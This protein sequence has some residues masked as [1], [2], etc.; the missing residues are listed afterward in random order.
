MPCLGRFLVGIA[1]TIATAAPASAQRV[2][3]ELDEF[4]RSIVERAAPLAVSVV[5]VRGD[6]VVHLAGYGL[7]DREQSLPVTPQS[8]FYIASSTK[9]FTAL[10]A[11]LLAARGAVDLDAPVSRYA[12]EF[13]LPP[14]LD[15]SRITLRRLLSHRAGFESG[16]VAFRTAYSGDLVPDSLL[17]VL[18]RSAV[19]V[20]TTFTYTNTAF[21]V[22]ARVLERA[23]DSPWQ[24][25]VAQEILNP[26]GLLRTTAVPSSASDWELVQGYGP[27][28]DGFRVVPPKPDETMH[29]AGGML[30]SG[31]DAGIW[32]RAQL[33]P[34]RVSG[35]QGLPASVIAAT[36]QPHAAHADTTDN[37]HRIGYA[38]GWQIGILDGDTLYYHLGNYPGAFAHVSFIPSRGIGVAV[39]ANS[40]LPAFGPVT[41][42]IATRAY[43]LLLDRRH[44]ER[45]Y[46]AFTDSIGSRRNRMAEIFRVDARR[47]A[48]RPTVPPRGWSVYAGHYYGGDMGSVTIVAHGDSAAELRYG[49]IRAPLEV[50]SGDTLRVEVPP[51]RSGRPMPVTFG[52]DGR[53]SSVTVA[54]TV[55]TRIDGTR[56]VSFTFDDLPATRFASVA[57]A[58]EMT[59]RLL[60]HI[61]ALKIPAVGFV[62]ESK[63]FARPGTSASMIR[64]L[65]AW[66]DVGA[67]LGNHTYSHLRLFDVPLQEV[68]TDVLRGE[69]E[70]RRLMAA[71]G[72]R[73]R[74]FRHP[75]L[76]TG[77]DAETKQ[78]F[79]RFLADHGY[80]VA[81][82]TIDN[83]EYLYALA[84]DRAR[85]RADSALMARLGHDYIRYMRE[86]F[87][88]YE[89]LSD[90]VL[91]REPAQILL[92]HANALNADYLDGLAAMIAER[93]YRFV[94]LEQALQDPAY[95]LPDHYVGPR[96]LSWL[97]RWAITRRRQPGEQPGVPDW[98]RAASR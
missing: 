89:A 4:V 98:V 37:I 45:E 22:A 56:A 81:P 70:T 35:R 14:P 48:E 6:S 7:R 62:N 61:R 68:Q 10:T 53:V 15:A 66:L 92:L 44:R 97:M 84:Y 75:T 49:Q 13:R 23:T 63:L 26:L 46:A 74:Y 2:E 18:S 59:T 94:S 71:R 64:L 55:F 5:V 11:A 69:R 42:T 96:G 27:G 51:G 60:A 34:G 38:L 47:R 43:D 40:E 78:A 54:D 80:A 90:S 9:S 41:G 57:D 32:L 16:A 65:D 77:P 85:E 79:E 36:H 33:A 88:F 83:D 93:G 52:A 3:P 87:Q 24:E 25:L 58:E 28:P 29:A 67:E 12:P 8:S 31:E 19:P 86:T 73:L 91:G 76:N 72:Q 95:Q 82:V 1:L 17:A 39:F 20:D 50:F 30:M 21:I